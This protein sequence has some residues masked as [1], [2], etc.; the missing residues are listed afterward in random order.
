ML[1]SSA[2]DFLLIDDDLKMKEVIQYDREHINLSSAVNF[3]NI[4]QS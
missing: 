1:F 3:I 2:A 4:T